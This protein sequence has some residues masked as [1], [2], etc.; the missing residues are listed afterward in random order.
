[1]NRKKGEVHCG[2]N[3]VKEVGGARFIPLRRSDLTILLGMLNRAV[4][5]LSRDGWSW[6]SVILVILPQ[7]IHPNH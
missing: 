3:F 4:P 7:F 1:M 2:S 6:F 5:F